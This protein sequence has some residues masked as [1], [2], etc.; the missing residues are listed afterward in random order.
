MHRAATK[1]VIQPALGLKRREHGL[2]CGKLHTIVILVFKWLVGETRRH[3]V[4]R[5]C[6]KV[7][8]RLALTRSGL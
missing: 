5:V 7:A 4:T 2:A 8:W 1:E 6:M 3:P